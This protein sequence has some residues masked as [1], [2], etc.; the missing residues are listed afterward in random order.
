MQRGQARSTFGEVHGVRPG[1]LRAG[2]HLKT[3]RGPR[4]EAGGG[5][6]RRAGA[7]RRRSRRAAPAHGGRFTDC[8]LRRSLNTLPRRPLQAA[9]GLGSCQHAAAL[10]SR[11]QGDRAKSVDKPG[12]AGPAIHCADVRRARAASDTW[13]L[14]FTYAR[15]IAAVLAAGRRHAHQHHGGVP[16]RTGLMRR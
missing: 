8:R 14:P 11:A 7:A 5:G 9:D 16:I 13:Q 3:A 2:F 12:L 4:L 6:R 10:L 1:I 15:T